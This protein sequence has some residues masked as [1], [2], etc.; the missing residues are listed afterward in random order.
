[1]DKFLKHFVTRVA[2]QST[3]TALGEC[4]TLLKTFLHAADAIDVT[5]Q[6][7]NRPTANMQEGK[8]FLSGNH[9][10]YGARSKLRFDRMN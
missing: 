9:K 4:E 5:F 10:L 1:M 8:L 6:E 2:K 7:A 3:M